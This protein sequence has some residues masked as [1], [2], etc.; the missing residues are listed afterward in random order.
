MPRA[1][2]SAR[3]RSSVKVSSSKKTS[4]TAGNSSVM[5]AISPSTCPALLVR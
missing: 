5:R 3:R 4:L 1:I 2:S